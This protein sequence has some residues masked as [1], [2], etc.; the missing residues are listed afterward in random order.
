[1]RRK[2][3]N[4]CLKDDYYD[5]DMVNSCFSILRML[6]QKHKELFNYSEF[7]FIDEYCD[8]R[9]EWI[10]GLMEELNKTKE[11]V[12]TLLIA[13]N[14]GGEYKDYTGKGYSKK[15]QTIS[16]NMNKN[17]GKILK[18]TGLYDEIKTEKNT[19]GSV[20]FSTMLLAQ[21][22]FSLVAT[23]IIFALTFS[24]LGEF[25]TFSDM[26]NMKEVFCTD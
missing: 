19:M 7:R 12:K 18:Q 11:E 1:M 2:V 3:R 6:G 10:N 23:L 26:I 16:Y 17:I 4:Y 25:I 8:N 15:L 5:F 24:I 14:F 9:Q 20:N 22:I 13:V 21:I